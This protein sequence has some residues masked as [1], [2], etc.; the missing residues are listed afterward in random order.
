M[1][2]SYFLWRQAGLGIASEMLLTGRQLSA[3][4]A[5][6]LGLVNELVEEPAELE[7]AARKVAGE[8]LACSRLGLQVRA[9]PGARRTLLLPVLLLQ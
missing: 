6:Q 1:G 9:A 3:E 7:A 4:R 2:T 5:Y 8:M